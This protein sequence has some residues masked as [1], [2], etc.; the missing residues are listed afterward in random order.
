[1]HH[2]LR[3]NHDYTILHTCGCACWLNLRPYNA[4]KLSFGSTRCVFLGYS[5]QHKGYK[6][7]EPTSYRVYISCDV[8]FDETTFP[9]ATLH[10]NAGALLKAKILLLHPTLRNL[11]EGEHVDEPNMANATDGTFESFVDT[12]HSDGENGVQNSTSSV[13][14]P[15]IV[16]A[17]Q[18]QGDIVAIEDLGKEITGDRLPAEASLDHAWISVGADQKRFPVGAAD[19]VPG[20]AEAATSPQNL[21]SSMSLGDHFETTQEH[22]LVPSELEASATPDSTTSGT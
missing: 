9:F 3:K 5:N 13:A 19:S 2:L 21:G 12:C 11:N 8:I 10:P 18:E 6:C 22:Q 14:N 20:V 4:H 7:L 16:D 1:M 17:N 15:V